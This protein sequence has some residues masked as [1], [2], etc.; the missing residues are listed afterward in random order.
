MSSTFQAPVFEAFAVHANDREVAERAAME[1][2]GAGWIV[3]P[4][5]E[6]STTFE[7]V[8]PAGLVVPVDRAWSLSY[9]LAAR[10]GM[11]QA[12]PVFLVQQPEDPEEAAALDDNVS[13]HGVA[14][15]RGTRR[16]PEHL[17]GS[18]ARDWSLRRIRVMDAWAK[19]FPDND[20][21]ATGIIVGHPDTGYRR[22][23]EIESALALDLGHDFVKDDDNPEDEL[24]RPWNVVVHNPGHG[25][26]TSS[27]I[28]SRKG[29]QAPYPGDPEARAVIGVAPGAKIIPLRVS[30][31]VVLTSM[32]NLA[33]AIEWA[34][35]KGAHVISISMGGLN[36][37]R[38][39]D[40]LR[41]ARERGVILLA[42]AGNY[43]RFVV[44]PAASS[45]AIGVAASNAEDHPWRHSSRGESVCV[46]APGE[47][48]WRATVNSEGIPN[49]GRGSGTSY[50]VATVAGVAALWLARHGRDNL[51][52]RYGAARIPVIFRELL[53]KTAAKCPAL[54]EGKFGA[55]LVDALKLLDEPLPDPAQPTRT[56]RAADTGME[57]QEPVGTI[58]HMFAEELSAP[59]RRR[60]GPGAVASPSDVIAEVLG[61]ATGELQ[62]EFGKEIAFH[63][64]T[65]PELYESFAAMLRL[66][67]AE[68]RASPA[69]DSQPGG[70]RRAIPRN[71]LRS[72]DQSL[73]DQLLGAASGP[74]A[75]RL[76][77]M[78]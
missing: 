18:S 61:D 12:E 10:E 57:Q 51:V 77:S 47:S 58:E 60:R 15:R 31:S 55:G 8:P 7:I 42:A 54:T 37:S 45:N 67:E 41:Y 27:V 5:G 23:P 20:E 44:W 2:L 4:Y 30:D 33:R 17:G 3:D 59:V 22:H 38:L 34:T 48:V 39:E 76:A 64:A 35:D 13:V 9:E 21:P 36:S 52:E 74:L 46:T 25:V 68:H 24:H 53:E 66:N 78:P 29:A 40:A 65:R 50:A 43:V 19:F 70:L 72:E 62:S 63:L 26:S 32:R 49:V 6:G 75:R 1:T 71:G 11:R 73:R 28:A 69:S 56:V 16:A 14:K